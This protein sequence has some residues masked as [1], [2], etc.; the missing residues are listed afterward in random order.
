MLNKFRTAT[1]FFIIVSL[2][3]SIAACGF[4]LRGSI[5][6]PAELQRTHIAGIA[7]FSLL[8]QELKRV[9][10]RSGTE[11]LSSATNA[12]S[13][14]T[15]SGEEFKRRVLSVD[16]QGRAA[17]YELNYRYRFSITDLSGASI[18]A[19]QQINLTRDYRFDPDNVLAKDAEETQ[20]RLDMVKFSVRQMMRR[21]QSQLKHVKLDNAND[22]KTTDVQTKDNQASG[23]QTNEAQAV[24]TESNDTQTK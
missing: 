14:I 1:R 13:I 22:T 18:V 20:I 3:L 12:K 2:F 23:T 19:L 21:V 11:V 4:R 16:A 15:I 10:Q 17:E 9:L 5:V 6:V 24:D 7:E 8:N